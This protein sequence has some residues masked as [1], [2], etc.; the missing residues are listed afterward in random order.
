[1]E[2][3]AGVERVLEPELSE[4]ELTGFRASCAHIRENVGRLSWW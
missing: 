1:M 2:L 3:L 4:D